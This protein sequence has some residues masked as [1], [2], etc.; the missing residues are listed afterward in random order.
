MF[1]PVY[2]VYLSLCMCLL[3]LHLKFLLLVCVCF[4][5]VCLRMFV[6]EYM[7]FLLSADS[8]STL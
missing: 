6:C 7:K 8:V 4:L 3:C 5:C 1:A 2:C